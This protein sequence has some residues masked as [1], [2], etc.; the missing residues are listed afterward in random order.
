[1]ALVSGSVRG[2]L[3]HAWGTLVTSSMARTRRRRRQH[4]GW[5]LGREIEG[6][7]LMAGHAGSW[8]TPVS[9]PAKMS[10]PPVVNLDG[11]AAGG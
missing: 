11:A 10:W 4:S 8:A 7:R 1:V 3:T 2:A 6:P 9:L 5:P